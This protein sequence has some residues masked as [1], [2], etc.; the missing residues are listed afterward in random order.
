MTRTHHLVSFSALAVSA[1][2][3]QPA[4]LPPQ[5]AAAAGGRFA[6]VRF[7][8]GAHQYASIPPE[9][10][11][12]GDGNFTIALWFSSTRGGVMLSKRESCWGGLRTA[13]GEDINLT[14][15]RR[16]VVEVRTSVSLTTLASPPGLS[17][18][19]WHHA[20]LVRR[21]G[22][23]FLA[24][25]G[26]EGASMRIVGS[27]DDPTQ[28]PTYLGVGRCVAGAP[29][30]NANSDSRTCFVGR[31][32]E[33]AFYWRALSRDELTASARGLCGP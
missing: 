7:I 13:T 33:V 26:A 28:T 20:A 24:V 19:L 27:L 31:I 23:I 32:D 16:V 1:L 10:G 4:C 11:N 8:D 30:A 25:D 21:A 12:F 18:G 29:G 15:V 14:D 17:D 22:M 9:V 2:C 5:P 6:P 3:L